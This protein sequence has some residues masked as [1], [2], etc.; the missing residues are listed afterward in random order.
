[1]EESSDCSQHGCDSQE[2]EEIASRISDLDKWREIF[3]SRGLELIDGVAQRHQ[4]GRKSEE[5]AEDAAGGPPST[6][7][8]PCRSGSSLTVPYSIPQ[9][10]TV[11]PS[12]GGQ[13]VTLEMA[14][15]LRKFLFGSALHVFNYEWKKSYFKFREPH[16]DLSY[17]VEAERGGARAIQMVVQ[18][19]IIKHLLFT[20]NQGAENGNLQRLYD[21]GEKEQEK[22][23]AV[24]LTDALWAAG[25]GVG[26]TVCLVTSDCCFTPSVD[27]KVDNFTERMQLFSFNE[28]EAT[29]SFIYEHIQCFKEE[30]SHGVILFLYSL[31]FS[32]TPDRLRDD[33]DFTTPH[34]L[35]LSLG[36]FVCRQALLN[37]MLTGRASPNVFNGDVQHDDQ[38]CLLPQPLRGVLARSDVGY[39]HW[40]RE[41]Q[42]QDKLPTVGS[43]LKTPKLPIWLCCINGTY[44]VLFSTNRSLL[45]DWKVEHLFDLCFYNGQPS[46]K[47]TVLLTI[48]THSHHWEE[49]R[50]VSKTVVDPEKRFPSVEMTIRTKWEG[51]AIDWNGTVPFF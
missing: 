1:M 9:A 3:S 49:E 8:K 47:N 38:G 11:S 35:Q 51:A 12:L 15:N 48:D 5:E 6:G 33:L 2:F 43:M 41:Q 26:T 34:L 10:L 24:A 40:D 21:V 4:E 30:G 28:K 31:I 25:E 36:N 23:L 17:A 7:C 18:A 46:Q 27:Y 50:G 14:L 45:S 44:S 20:R 37:L 42:D 13:P 32:R 39:L 29:W 19:N 16:S 22:A